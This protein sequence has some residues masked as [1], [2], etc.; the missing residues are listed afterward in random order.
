MKTYTK[1]KIAFF[2]FFAFSIQIH[3]QGNIDG[4]FSE[5]GALSVTTSYTNSSFDEFYA[6]TTLIKSVPD[7][8]KITQD[9]FNIYAKYELASD[10]V[11]FLNIP[12][13]VAKGNGV[14]DS[15]NGNTEVSGIQDVVFGL[16][17]KFLKVK[18]DTG[19]F[20][21]I[22][23]VSFHIPADYEPNGI[24]SIGTGS[25][26][27]DFTGGIHYQSDFGYFITALATYSH[28]DDVQFNGNFIVPNAFLGLAKLG[29]ANRWI[30]VD[31][32]LDYTASLSGVDINDTTNNFPETQVVFTRVGGTLSKKFGRSGFAASLGASTVLDGKNTGKATTLSLGLT[33]EV[34]LL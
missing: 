14:A 33:Y 11:T 5:V 13:V 34:E 28:R 22:G 21:V 31:G 23:G 2:T 1:L 26:N 19:D 4:F 18:N 6:G 3:A 16:K 30:Y 25:F 20:N 10:L 12:Y 27:T 17:Y 7:H 15:V 32:W 29:Y 24:L 8:N 9:I